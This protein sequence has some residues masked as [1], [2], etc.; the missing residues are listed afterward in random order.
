MDAAMYI[1]YKAETSEALAAEQNNDFEFFSRER[2]TVSTVQFVLCRQTQ[3]RKVH[4]VTKKLQ[5]QKLFLVDNEW[6]SRNFI[7]FAIFVLSPT[8]SK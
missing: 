8:I 5:V 6:T 3:C 7:L 1:V 2:P 4:R